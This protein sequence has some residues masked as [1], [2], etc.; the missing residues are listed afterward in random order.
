MLRRVP[1][2]LLIPLD[3]GYPDPVDTPAPDFGH[4]ES[5]PL[6]FNGITHL[7]YAP[8]PVD[9]QSANRVVGTGGQLDAGPLNELVETEQPVDQVGAVSGLGLPTHD[10]RRH[11][12]GTRRRNRTGVASRGFHPRAHDHV[13]RSVRG[14]AHYAAGE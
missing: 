2:I 13:H 6:L 12:L 8:Q 4:R 14:T 1:L 5:M 7:G 9:H 11:P 10:R 3:R